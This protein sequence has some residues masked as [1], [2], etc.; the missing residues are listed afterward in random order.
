ML[1]LYISE[2]CPFSRKVLNFFDDNHIEYIKKD[3]SESE[4]FEKLMSLGG[5]HQVPFLYDKDND[6]KM[7]ESD[8]IIDY[9]S[10]LGE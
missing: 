6:V 2:S 3:I 9:V 7:Y 5:I 10:E 1:E 4:N 8:D